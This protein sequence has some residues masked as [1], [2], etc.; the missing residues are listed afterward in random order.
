MACLI[1]NQMVI[2]MFFK[3]LHLHIYRAWQGSRSEI[4]TCLVYGIH[5]IHT[6]EIVENGI[7]N[8][9]GGVE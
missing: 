8:Y 2:R 1:D 4:D 3:F 7:F 9:R 5:D 6:K